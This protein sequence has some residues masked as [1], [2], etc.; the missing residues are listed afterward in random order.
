MSDVTT[1]LDS[2]GNDVSATV[3]PKVH[4]FPTALIQDL[5]TAIVP[6]SSASSTRA[7]SRTASR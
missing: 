6:S 2:I 4:D 7:S 5:R 1:F 3:A